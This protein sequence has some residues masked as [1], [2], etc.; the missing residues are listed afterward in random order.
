M[1][2]PLHPVEFRVRIFVALVDGVHESPPRLIDEVSYHDWLAKQDPHIRRR[3]VLEWG[4]VHPACI[5]EEA[6][7]NLMSA[8]DARHKP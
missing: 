8:L 6:H 2:A 7:T 5:S 1:A 3:P 4:V